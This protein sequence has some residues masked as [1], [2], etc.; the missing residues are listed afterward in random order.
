M[1]YTRPGCYFLKFANGRPYVL[2]DESDGQ[3]IL[4]VW[5]D[6]F[7]RAWIPLSWLD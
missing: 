6:T 2:G 1:R 7:E 5:Q 4:C 3:S